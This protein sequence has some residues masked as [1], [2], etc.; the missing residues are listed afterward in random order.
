MVDRTAR[1]PAI[2]RPGR[3]FVY[4][5]IGVEAPVQFNPC[6]RAGVEKSTCARSTTDVSGLLIVRYAYRGVLRS[7]TASH[8]V[9]SGARSPPSIH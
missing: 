5:A 3:Q 8:T 1:V 4:R 7:T 9:T 6:W 2:Q